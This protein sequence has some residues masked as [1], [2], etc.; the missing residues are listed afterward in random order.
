MQTNGDFAKFTANGLEGR[1]IS[2]LK[3]DLSLTHNDIDL[4]LYVGSASITTTGI[5]TSGTWQGTKITDSYINSATIWNAKQDALTNG[6]S[7]TNNVVINSSSVENGDYAKFTAGG[8][9]GR[10]INEL[11]TDLSLT[12]NDIDLSS[13]SGSLSISTL[14]TVTSGSWQGSTINESYI[15][16]SIA[17]KSYV[18]SV[19]SRIRY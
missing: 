5:I 9:E 8:L 16:S 11:K 18:D 7:D 19:V 13:Y 17:R 6:I 15:D 1:T 12:H 3:S 2:E 4:S 14:G 10:S